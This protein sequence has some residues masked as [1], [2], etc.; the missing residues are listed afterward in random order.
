MSNEM[1]DGVMNEILN[2]TCILDNLSYLSTSKI[3]LL[4]FLF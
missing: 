3:S 1:L 2:T 4:L